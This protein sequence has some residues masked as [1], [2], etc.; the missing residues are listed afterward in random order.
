LICLRTTG[1]SISDMQRFAELLRVGDESVR[2]RIELLQKH[3]QH[4]L[5]MIAEIETKLA[6]VDG[7]ISHYE[8]K[9][10]RLWNER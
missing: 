5:Q 4:M 8:A 9:E 7:K 2:E 3:R 10:K 6:V 1:M